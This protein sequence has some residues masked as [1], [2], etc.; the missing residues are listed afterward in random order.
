MITSEGL[1]L[2]TSAWLTR[3]LTNR[4]HKKQQNV[5][6]YQYQMTQ[7]EYQ[8]LRQCLTHSRTYAF[9]K[10][11]SWDWCGAFT[12]Y[13]AEWFRREYTLAWS[14]EPIFASLGFR[15]EPNVIADVVERGLNGYWGRYVSQSH[16]KQHHYL[17]S[18]F[19][20]GGLP[21]NLLANDD[22]NY[23]STFNVTDHSRAYLT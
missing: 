6:L 9:S 11:P 4:H 14:W 22:N 23:Q 17:G 2:S 1:P 10:E 12:L 20:E 7:A 8:S 16:A 19:R 18:V 15:L 13:C 3:F 5:S 21:S